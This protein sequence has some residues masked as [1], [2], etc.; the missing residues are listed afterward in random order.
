M[1]LL[2]LQLPGRPANAQISYSTSSVPFG[3]TSLTNETV[4][5]DQDVS[6]PVTIPFSFSFFKTSYSSLVIGRDGFISFRSS[7]LFPRPCCSPQLLPD[8]QIPNAIIAGYWG[9]LQR[10]GS[11]LYGTAVSQSNQRIFVVEFRDVPQSSSGNLVKFQIKLF[12][13]S[14]AIEIHCASCP[15]PGDT[16][17]HTQGIED[18][19]GSVAFLLPGRNFSR[20]SLTGDAI[21]FSPNAEDDMPPARPRNLRVQ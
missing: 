12:E 11:I 19:L 8:S 9:D 21:K 10:G 2:G 17:V 3:F 13:G 7:D 1:L 18:P 16:S 6:S 4:I 15:S 14:N 20:F 5:P